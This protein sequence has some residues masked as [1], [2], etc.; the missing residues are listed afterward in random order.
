M[1]N[2]EVNPD[3]ICALQVNATNFLLETLKENYDLAIFARLFLPTSPLTPMEGSLARFAS[4]AL[5]SS[6]LELVTQTSLQEEKVT[7]S[8]KTHSIH[9]VVKNSP[10]HIV[11]GVT[12]GQTNFNHLAFD[13]KLLYDMSAEKEVPFVT[14]KPVDY[15]P[16]INDV[17]DRL[18]L[19][20][21]IKVLSSHHEDNFFRLK[22]LVWDPTQAGANPAF[23]YSHPIKVIS[24]PMKQRKPRASSTTASTKRARSAPSVPATPN[25][26]SASGS[27]LGPEPMLSSLSLPMPLPAEVSG[28]ALQKLEQQQNEAL[29]LLR[30]VLDMQHLQQGQL[31]HLLSNSFNN[32]N[33]SGYVNNS[34]TKPQQQTQ[35]QLPPIQQIPQSVKSDSNFFQFDSGQD[36]ASSKKRRLEPVPSP[37][38]FGSQTSN[39]AK[40]SAESSFFSP[41]FGSYIHPITVNKDKFNDNTTTNTQ[42]K[43]IEGNNPGENNTNAPGDFEGAFSEML[44]IYSSL[45]AEQK[46]ERVRKL[47]RSF[48][49]K[50]LGVV[51]VC[52]RTLKR[53]MP[54]GTLRCLLN[55]RRVEGKRT[56]VH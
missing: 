46:A 50:E 16:Y 48:S 30:Q 18:T 56:F 12:N 28:P 14:T 11:L 43:E 23:V 3:V 33:L 13:M 42:N 39:A 26:V 32:L 53:L 55:G 15:K 22:I 10:F 49:M 34:T 20:I 9:V 5:S 7:R 25:S 17:G 45:T 19:D 2:F 41:S 1:N 29:S 37:S 31:Q 44:A 52:S 38:L 40:S 36:D 6:C 21:K 24:K 4:V 54:L 35:T 8:G 47:I 51:E 27:N